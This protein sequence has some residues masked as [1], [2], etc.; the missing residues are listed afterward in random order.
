[1]KERQAPSAHAV[2][3]ATGTIS[4]G[5][6][7]AKWI[8]KN[9]GLTGASKRWVRLNVELTFDGYKWSDGYDLNITV[10]ERHTSFM[11]QD[12]TIRKVD[13]R[14]K[15]ANFSEKDVVLVMS[16]FHIAKAIGVSDEVHI[17]GPVD[18]GKII[19]AI[20]K[21]YK[22]KFTREHYAKWRAALKPYSPKITKKVFKWNKTPASAMAADLEKHFKTFGD[23]QGD[24]VYYGGLRK[25]A[26]SRYVVDF[27]S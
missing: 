3:T 5:A 13:L 6:D 14:H 12:E 17:S 16:H 21:F 18:A 1:M 23:A 27:D 15:R 4:L 26:E 19:D 9:V 24:T 20:A 2:E 11:I 25:I 22:Q 10:D 8:V 7:G